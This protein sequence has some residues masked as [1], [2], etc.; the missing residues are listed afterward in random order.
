MLRGWQWVNVVVSAEFQISVLYGGVSTSGRDSMPSRDKILHPE[1][2]T[3]KE[4]SHFIRHILWF[5][6][7]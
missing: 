5:H 3:W 4:K 2:K 6:R 1:V 7:K